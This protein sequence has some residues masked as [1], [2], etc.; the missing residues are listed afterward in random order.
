MA[1]R[2]AQ[3]FSSARLLPSSLAVAP[4]CLHQQ[5][6]K[7]LPPTVCLQDAAGF[8]SADSGPTPTQ[9]VLCVTVAH[10]QSPEWILRN[11]LRV[12]GLPAATQLETGAAPCWVGAACSDLLRC[13]PPA[14]AACCGCLQELLALK[15]PCSKAGL[16]GSKQADNEAEPGSMK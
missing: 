14:L 9:S 8:A 4:H 15:R 6:H 16:H 7:D 2:P 5:Q 10:Q 1:I 12:L 11:C 13:C 3:V